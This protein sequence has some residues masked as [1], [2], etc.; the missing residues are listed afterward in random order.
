MD[1]FKL[2]IHNLSTKIDKKDV[3]NIREYAILYNEIMKSCL[4]DID[5]NDLFIQLNKCLDQ[6]INN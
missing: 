4:V 1:N 6:F 3:D 5:K 2:R